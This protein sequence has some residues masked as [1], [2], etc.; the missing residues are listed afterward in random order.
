MILKGKLIFTCNINFFKIDVASKKSVV[1]CNNIKK[2]KK[3][4]LSNY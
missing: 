3:V 1:A 4:F 2:K